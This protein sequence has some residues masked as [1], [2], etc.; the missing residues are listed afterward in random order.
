MEI[1]SLPTFDSIGVALKYPI[2]LDSSG[3]PVTVTGAILVEQSIITALL[4]NAP[5]FF[6]GKLK[7]RLD[8]LTFEQNDEILLSLLDYFI[9]ETAKEWESRTKIISIDFEKDDAGVVL[10]KIRHQL[11]AENTVSTFIFPYSNELIF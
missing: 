10:C 1:I 9:R 8:E 4:Y 5:S 7:S 3:N 11:V 2:E 6:L